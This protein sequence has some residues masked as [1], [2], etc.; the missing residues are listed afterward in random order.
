MKIID[1]ITFK[2]TGKK[3]PVIRVSE[4]DQKDGRI[5]SLQDVGY[6]RDDPNNLF[7]NWD[8]K[9]WEKQKDTIPVMRMSSKGIVEECWI[10][11]E[12]GQTVN[13]YTQPWKGP[14]LENVL[15]EMVSVDSISRAM[16]LEPSMRD[17]LIFMVVGIFLGWLIVGP[18]IGGMLS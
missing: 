7:Y 9:S 17:K 16:G 3:V 5:L 14:A 2:L 6:V 13:L 11:S 4:V 12:R 10:V 15:G 1:Q 18:M 8:N